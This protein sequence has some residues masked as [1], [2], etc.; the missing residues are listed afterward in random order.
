MDTL[1][2]HDY[3]TTGTDP[4]FD[5]P[6]QF[7]GV[8]TDT[9]LNI[10][11]EPLMIYCQPPTDVLPHPQASLVTGIPPRLAAE[12]GLTEA[13]FMA[14]I[15]EQLSVPGTCGVGYNS[16]RFDDEFT[17]FGL[18]RNFYD[19][20][21]REWQ[22]GNSRWDIIDMARLTRAL[23]PEGI[24]WPNRDDG[25]PSF[26]LEALTA[27][28][29]IAHQG[30]HD[31]LVDVYA[32]IA[33]AKLIK[34]KHLKLYQHVYG[35]RRKQ[36]V[37]P[38]LNLR[39][40]TPVLHVSGMY[41]AEFCH[42][43]LVVP[44]AADP[45]NQNGVIVFDLRQDPRLLIEQDVDTLKQWLFTAAADLPEEATRPALKTVHINKCPIIVPAATLDKAAAARLSID[46]AQQHQ[47]FQMV[48]ENITLIRDKLQQI[49]S[50]KQFA[51]LDEV[52]ASL[53]GGGFF[54]R[55]DKNK[56]ALIREASPEQLK[57]LSIPFDDTR[58]SEMLFRYR[59]RNWPDSLSAA[60]A[61]Q[62]Q[63]FR[64]KKLNTNSPHWLS[65]A[66][67]FETI[68][69]CRID[70]TEESQQQVL[71]QLAQWGQ[72]LQRQLGDV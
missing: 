65:F 64:Q 46:R 16:L 25:H 67:Y 49:F 4:R 43:A 14:A 42:A 36:Q 59:A 1:Y 6:I 72:Q 24:E 10:I 28:N 20:Y 5:R 11:G 38:L 33:L 52:D 13:D 35:L 40:P 9:E 48:V 17:R 56:M 71:A 37:A 63:Q 69:Q 62:W 68:Q 27:A 7:A 31:A 19:A 18:F 70:T 23:R 51:D 61:E 12:H 54:S 8:R 22:N 47:H 2:W 3:E 58:L 66:S 45:N 41:P 30:A 39:D 55:A 34:T 26:R 29:G 21:E 44:V 53:Y 50:D 60:E 57:T 32:T 15:H